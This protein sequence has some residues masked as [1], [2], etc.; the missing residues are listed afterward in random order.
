MDLFDYMREKEQEKELSLIHIYCSIVFSRASCLLAFPGLRIRNRSHTSAL[1][2]Y[3]LK[4]PRCFRMI[5][6]SKGI[7]DKSRLNAQIQIYST[8]RRCV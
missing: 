1:C 5:Y 7:P 8:S 6:F 4:N 3:V 2:E